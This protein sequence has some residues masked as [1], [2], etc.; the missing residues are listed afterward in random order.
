M[1]GNDSINSY[2]NFLWLLA[3]VMECNL[4]DMEVEYKKQGCVLRHDAKRHMKA[5]IKSI[6][7]LTEEINKLRP[8]VQ[9]IFAYDADVLN[10]MIKM[11]VDRYGDNHYK[12][13]R[14]YNVMERLVSEGTGLPL[15]DKKVAFGH[16]MMED[17]QV[18]LC[19]RCGS[20][21]IESDVEGVDYECGSCEVGFKESEVVTKKVR[22]V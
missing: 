3:D 6:K 15:S 4:M 9:N 13:L 18:K 22:L 5:A 19:P 12:A 20:L 8:S 16:V 2:T 14:M 17:G 7:C 21:L 11:M 10:A 1:K